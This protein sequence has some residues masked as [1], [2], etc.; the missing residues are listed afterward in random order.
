[1]TRETPGVRRGRN[2][3]HDDLRKRR[4]TMNATAR[5]REQLLDAALEMT[6]PA[7]DPIAVGAAEAHAR[8]VAEHAAPRRAR[9][10][11]AAAGQGPRTTGVPPRSR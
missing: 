1:M 9:K 2:G 4:L 6:F 8:P 5:R 7:S 10:Q 3:Y 11:V